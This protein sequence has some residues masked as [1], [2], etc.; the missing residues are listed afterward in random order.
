M[1]NS[2]DTIGNRSRDFP[3]FSSV[4]RPTAPS[5]TPPPYESRSCIKSDILM[6]QTLQITVYI[7]YR[8]ITFRAFSY[9]R[10]L[11]LTPT[12]YTLFIYCIVINIVRGPG[13]SVDIGTD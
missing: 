6:T 3:V 8:R 12:I 2:S 13:S 11:K 5:R 10:R 1:K 7:M 4:P 9:I